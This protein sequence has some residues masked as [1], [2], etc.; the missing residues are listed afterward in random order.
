MAVADRSISEIARPYPLTFGAISKHLLVLE[1]A[2]LIEK[3][4]QGKQQIVRIAPDTLD[5]VTDM[6]QGYRD[7][8]EARF[9]R[10]DALLEGQHE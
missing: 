1:R 3:R 9:R 8:W 10:L 7:L 4:R 5:R 6:L 2:D